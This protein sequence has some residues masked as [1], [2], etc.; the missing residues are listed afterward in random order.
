MDDGLST[1]TPRLGVT[2]YTREQ[3][4][5]LKQEPI[6]EE[7]QLRKERIEWLKTI[8]SFSLKENQV[9]A[10]AACLEKRCF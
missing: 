9:V 6:P 5:A 7:M 10:V 1:L 2:L 8:D 4:A 3:I